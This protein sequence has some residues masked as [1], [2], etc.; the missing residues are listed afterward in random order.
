MLTGIPTD[1]GRKERKNETVDVK[2]WA[3]YGGAECQR[4]WRDYARQ[5]DY[6]DIRAAESIF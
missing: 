1:T 2:R 6:D 3:E 4:C 5:D